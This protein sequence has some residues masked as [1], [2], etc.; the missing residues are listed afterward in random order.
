MTCSP[1]RPCVGWRKAPGTV[2][3]I[4][5]PSERH[6]RAAAPLVLTIFAVRIGGLTGSTLRGAQPKGDR[7]V[8]ADA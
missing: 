2:P 4:V 5:N 7:P 8:G 6:S 1:T 3:M